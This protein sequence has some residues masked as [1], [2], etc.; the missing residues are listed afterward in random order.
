MATYLPLHKKR[1][2]VETVARAIASACKTTD[3][4]E[5]PAGI[6]ELDEDRLAL[7]EPKFP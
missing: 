5:A 3:R 1:G 6:G 4:F 7:G 2:M